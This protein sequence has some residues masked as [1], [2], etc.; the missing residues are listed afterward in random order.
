MR[1]VTAIEL[2][3]KLN[4]KWIISL[5]KYNGVVLHRIVAR[6]TQT[7]RIIDWEGASE[8]FEVQKENRIL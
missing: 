3:C 7:Q 6:E 4:K 2:T 1:N 8:S 5:V